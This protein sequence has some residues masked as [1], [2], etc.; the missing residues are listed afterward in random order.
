MGER[1]VLA[2]PKGAVARKV[3]FAVLLDASAK[4]LIYSVA[5]VTCDQDRKGLADM[6]ER[7]ARDLRRP[8]RSRLALVAL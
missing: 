1:V 7:V 6:L 3:N 8:K 4:G 5:G 2:F